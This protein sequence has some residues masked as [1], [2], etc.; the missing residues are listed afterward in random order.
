[1]IAAAERRGWGAS[2]SATHPH[3]RRPVHRPA[4]MPHTAAAMRHLKGEGYGVLPNADNLAFIP[5]VADALFRAR[6]CPCSGAVRQIHYRRPKS[7]HPLLATGH[8]GGSR[9]ATRTHAVASLE[10]SGG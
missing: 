10:P 9:R 3:R 1:M 7:P 6:T 2:S 8:S 4:G 5:L